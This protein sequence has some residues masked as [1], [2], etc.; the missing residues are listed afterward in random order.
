MGGATPAAV[1]VRAVSSPTGSTA[2]ARPAARTVGAE[3][4]DAR[5][6]TAAVQARDAVEAWYAAETGEFI[7][8]RKDLKDKF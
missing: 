7:A 1:A 4:G 6:A 2:A 8:E 5:H 3:A